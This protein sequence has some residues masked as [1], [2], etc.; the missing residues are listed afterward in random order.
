MRIRYRLALLLAL[1]ALAGCP[2]DAPATPTWR[3]DVMPIL[4]T[5]CVRCHGDQA[6]G[7]APPTFRF[8]IYDDVADPVSGR[9]WRGAR[10]MAP[11]IAERAGVQGTMPP[12][13][14][15]LSPRQRDVLIN[16]AAT[17]SGKGE[18]NT[19]PTI[20]VAVVEDGDDVVISYRISDAD[21]DAVTGVLDFPHDPI[22]FGVNLDGT[23]HSG[24]GEV[25]IDTS[26]IL[27]GTY[28]LR[29][30]LNDSFESVTIPD[31]ATI[32]VAHANTAPSVLISQPQTDQIVTDV[33]DT[34]CGGGPQCLSFIVRACRE[35]DDTECGEPDGPETYLADI[36]AFRG[37][38]QVPIAMGVAVVVGE[39]T[40]PWDA[41]VLE[42]ADNWQ[43]RVTVSDG[44]S[45]KSGETG[46]FVV[47][48]GMTNKTFDAD[49][50]PIIDAHCVPCH[51]YN[52]AGPIAGTPVPEIVMFDLDVPSYKDAVVGRGDMYRR[53]F[54]YQH[55]PLK[56]GQALVGV[57]PLSAE[58]LATLR[59]WYRAG[60]P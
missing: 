44:T 3:D 45:Q 7:G 39:N 23:L 24:T 16:W 31:L 26:Q 57:G 36:V 52:A 46:P 58:E 40:L 10:L 11:F 54:N 53:V 38:T 49:I 47:G 56:S 13:G 28:A 19:A 50:K 60:S 22:N 8:D 14:L 1:V 42:Q 41:S 30:V 33:P 43:V 12:N 2:A 37:T 25:R 18:A 6:T 5:N 17:M 4:R 51:G 9:Y 21:H 29:A 27:P 15:E 20:T 34:S 55:M 32:T 48:H 35:V 59:E